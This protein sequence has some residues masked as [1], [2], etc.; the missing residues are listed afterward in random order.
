MVHQRRGSEFVSS[1]K[2]DRAEAEFALAIEYNPRYAA[3][4][5]GMGLVAHRRGQWQDA[6]AL[7]QEALI[8]DDEF[9]E[10]YNNRGAVL[11]QR[12]GFGDAADDFRAALAIDPGF[13]NARYNL[14]L[15]QLQLGD[16]D[17]AEFELRKLVAVN[18]SLAIA[19]AE[20]GCLLVHQGRRAAAHAQLRRAIELQ[21]DLASAHRCRG[22]LQ[23]QAGDLTGAMWTLEKALRMDPSDTLARQE[24]VLALLLSGNAPRAGRIVATLVHRWPASAVAHFLD[25][26]VKRRCGDMRGAQDAFQ[27]ALSRRS[28]YPAAHLELAELHRVDGRLGRAREHYRA[29]LKRVP[30]S[31][32][33]YRGVAA[34]RLSRDAR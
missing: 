14:A 9:A 8:I 25:G 6:L 12:Q 22:V 1:G 23:R 16:L 29:F 15:T 32:E 2:L 7:F 20:L 30:V 13:V 27:R 19:R 26:F 28:D 24:L 34:A 17:D 10:A 18:P 31:L 5:N 3:A 11:L 33:S 4:F 21:S